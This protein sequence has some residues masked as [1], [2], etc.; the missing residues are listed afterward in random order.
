MHAST[1]TSL[2]QD[3]R[4]HSPSMKQPA[5]ALVPTAD[6]V[7]WRTVIPFYRPSS[8]ND[9]AVLACINYY[10]CTLMRELARVWATCPLSLSQ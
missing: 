4:D 10:Y 2:K 7:T 3:G 5:V 8:D 6:C 9:L 1:A